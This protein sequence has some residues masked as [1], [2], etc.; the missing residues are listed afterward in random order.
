MREHITEFHVSKLILKVI[1][2]F[3][4]IFLMY[5]LHFVSDIV[6]LRTWY[7][8]EVPRY[9]NPVTTLLGEWM[10]MK[11]VGQLRYEQG[12]AVPQ[13]QDSLYKVSFKNRR[14]DTLP[15]IPSY[16]V[17]SIRHWGTLKQ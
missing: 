12:L 8:V 17:T 5:F 6:F 16:I 11:T 15:V 2:L 7:P 9:Y 13:K 10:G 4:V 1:N 3:V 14:K